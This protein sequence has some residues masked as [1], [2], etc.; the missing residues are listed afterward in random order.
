MRCRVPELPEV[1]TVVRD[2]CPQLIGRRL[3]RVRRGSRHT[4]RTPWRPAWNAAVV[5][6]RVESVG[7]RGKW[8]LVELEN[9]T[10]LVVHLGMTGQLTVGPSTAPV[11]DH[12]HL[13]FTL[14][15][16]ERQLRFRDIRRFG[17]VT[18]FATR[19]ELHDFFEQSGLGPEP[20]DLPAKYWRERLRAAKRCIKAVLLDQGIV[21]GVGNIYADESLFAARLHPARLA[22]DLDDAESDRLRRAVATVL[23][24]AI[25]RRG[26]SIRDYVGGSG[27]QGEYQDELRV[28]GRTGEACPRCGDAIVCLRLAG[29]SSHFCPTCQNNAAADHTEH[30]EKRQKKPPKRREKKERKEDR[31]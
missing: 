3:T 19:Q 26:S 23:Q 5:G 6:Q 10:F 13:I 1:E 20:F 14:E 31:G 2:L 21:A 17:S 18:L 12:T 7:R 30:T 29:R 9:H 28:Y 4:L 16:G 15:D 25:E 27:L 24:R 11:A 22:C 8:I